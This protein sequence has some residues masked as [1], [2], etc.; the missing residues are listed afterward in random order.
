MKHLTNLKKWLDCDGD[1]TLALDWPVDELSLVWEIGGYEGRWTK[2]MVEKHGCYIEVFEPQEW[3]FKKLQDQFYDVP[4]VKVYPYGL[5]IRDDFLPIGS[6]F[7]DGASIIKKGDGDPTHAGA[8]RDIHREMMHVGVLDVCLMN[9][10]GAEWDLIPYMIAKNDM[11]KID[12]FWCQFHPG[13]IENPDQRIEDIFTK[14]EETHKLLW[15]CYPTAVA[16]RRKHDSEAVDLSASLFAK[17]VLEVA[18]T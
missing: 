6:F 5:W 15:N 9:I 1:N 12:N 10:E 8:F 14:M 7:T 11:M 18:E 16:W 2:Q 13:L 3:A 4:A 17:P